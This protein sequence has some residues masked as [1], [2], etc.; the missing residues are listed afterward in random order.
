MNILFVNYGDHSTNSLNHIGPFANYLTDAGHQCIVAIPGNLRSR[1]KLPKILFKTT[2]YSDLLSLAHHFPNGKPADVIHAWTPR[3]NVLNFVHSYQAR[4]GREARLVVHMEDNEKAILEHFYDSNWEDLRSRQFPEGQDRWEP[5]LC[6]PTQFQQFL[7]NADGC[8]AVIDTLFDFLP[9]STPR[10]ELLP[11]IDFQSEPTCPV[12]ISPI[13]KQL[14]EDEKTIVY[15]GGVTSS[16]R[17]DIANLYDAVYLLRQRGK[18]VRLLKTGPNHPSLL[19]SCRYTSDDHILD[20]GFLPKERLTALIQNAH[21]LV[22]PGDSDPFNDYRLPSKLPEFLASGRPVI[23]GKI[24]LGLRLE[25]KKEA[26]LVEKTDPESIA[27]AYLEIDSNPQLHKALSQ[28][29]KRYA[30]EH[31]ALSRNGAMLLEFYTTLTSSRKTAKPT[32]YSP[33]PQKIESFEP[34]APSRSVAQKLSDLISAVFRKN[35]SSLKIEGHSYK[36]PVPPL[37]PAVDQTIVEDRELD[38]EIYQEREQAT[39]SKFYEQA[40]DPEKSEAQ[41]KFSILLPTYKPDL[42]LLQQAIDSV[43][44]QRYRNWE[45]CIIDDASNSRE[46]DSFLQNYAEL[47]GRI[48]YRTLEQNRHIAAATNIA[49]ELSSGSYCGFL[50]H[51]DL[52]S[53]HALQMVAETIKSHPDASILF[54]D[55]DKIDLNNNRSTPYFKPDWDPTF[56]KCQNYTGHFSV[57]RSSLLKNVGGLREDTSGSQDWDLI[58]RASAKCDL[59]SIVHIPHILYHWRTTPVSTA[60]SNENKNYAYEAAKAVLGQNLQ[61]EERPVEIKEHAGIYLYPRYQTQP[62]A[63]VTLIVEG[64][65]ETTIGELPFNSQLVSLSQA[66]P[67]RFEGSLARKRNQAIENSNTEFICITKG[68]L[69]P[70]SPSWLEDLVAFASQLEVGLVGART[71]TTT[72]HTRSSPFTLPE[73]GIRS[74]QFCDLHKD[75]DGYFHRALLNSSFPA[76]SSDCIVFR[77]AL[78]REVGGYSEA[79]EDI[80]SIDIDFCQKLAEA[81]FRSIYT[82]F[83]T[84]ETNSLEPARPKLAALEKGTFIL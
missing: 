37:Q 76:I 12:D 59:R 72:G 33:P 78:W 65:Q 34:V 61:R 43:R 55:E 26:F 11:G 83:I 58:L 18:K 27:E 30:E 81:G 48:K 67:N 21:V 44:Q 56:I 42:Q 36:L 1:S 77:K 60:T 57:Y 20:L 8:T 3:I 13:L 41:I 24:N 39:L 53:E 9:S 66:T 47:D 22:Q 62:R 50:D 29:G 10:I 2:S 14:E 40:P 51:D 71:L 49:L 80:D 82:P 52:L 19:E 35:A 69:A 46:L 63:S 16:N 17:Q 75:S 68:T 6:H 74:T 31:F 25:D 7:E 73:P 54:S 64:A 70:Q 79:L 32:S 84:L 45:L 5:M 38:Y 28:N 23:T 4:F 15:S